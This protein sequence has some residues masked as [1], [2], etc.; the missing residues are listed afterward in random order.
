MTLS[1]STGTLGWKNLRC[2]VD[3]LRISARDGEES[4]S[5]I[6]DSISILSKVD[7][8]KDWADF[9][10]Y[11]TDSG[12]EGS[13][14]SG[15]GINAKIVDIARVI[16]VEGSKSMLVLRPKPFRFWSLDLNDG[17]S[18]TGLDT[19]GGKAGKYGWMKT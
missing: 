2:V 17:R 1:I 11:S 5:N 9:L 7:C 8:A 3:D 6:S 4:E 19:G 13:S 14:S 15:C 12:L 18:N 16:G 10:R